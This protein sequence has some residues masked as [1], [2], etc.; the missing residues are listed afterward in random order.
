VRLK[1][2]ALY[3]KAILIV[4]AFCFIVLTQGMFG[5][6]GFFALMEAKKEKQS[7]QDEIKKMEEEN[8]A[9]KDKI[10]DIKNNKFLLEKKAREKLLMSKP[11]EIIFLTPPK[12]DANK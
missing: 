3:R 5:G 6:K 4:I 2:L 10:N 9:L 8:A 7:L 11:K 12:N 1:R